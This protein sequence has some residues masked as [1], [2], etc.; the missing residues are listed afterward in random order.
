MYLYIHNPLI[1]TSAR[2]FKS[3]QTMRAQY[4][5][6]FSFGLSMY[7][8]IIYLF[9]KEGKI[10]SVRSHVMFLKDENLSYTDVYLVRTPLTFHRVTH[11]Y[12]AR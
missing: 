7:F 3:L 4:G 6:F 11:M 9:V 10:A 12:D 1:F 2:H 8:I 5:S